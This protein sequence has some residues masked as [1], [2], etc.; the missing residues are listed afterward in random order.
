MDEATRRYWETL[1]DQ[2]IDR[3]VEAALG[4]LA[5]QAHNSAIHLY[6][7]KGPGSTGIAFEH[8]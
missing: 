2:V 5:E 7:L 3:A 1:A 6:R 8:G 4:D